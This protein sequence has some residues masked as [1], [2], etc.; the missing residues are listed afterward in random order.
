MLDYARDLATSAERTT[1]ALSPVSAEAAARRP[2]PGKWSVKEII[3]HLVDSALDWFMRDYVGH[4]HHHL[5]QVAALVPLSS[6]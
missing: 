3:G 1:R 6:P 5:R 4:L 2:A